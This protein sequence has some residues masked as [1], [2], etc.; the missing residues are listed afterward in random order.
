MGFMM[1]C[2]CIPELVLT[3]H[4]LIIVVEVFRALGPTHV[5]KLWLM[6]S[7]GMHPVECFCS[8]KSSLCQLN[9]LKII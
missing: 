1:H 7:K 2:S 8:S 6:V 9:F 3:P 5:L 4:F